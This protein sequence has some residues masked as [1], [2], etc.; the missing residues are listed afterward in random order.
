MAVPWRLQRYIFR[1]MGKTFVLT[2]LG[3]TGVLSL[4]GGV[5]NMIRL[6]EITPSQL[7]RLLALVVP[8]AA[9]L[10]LPVAALFSATSTYGRISADNEFVACRA[11]GINLHVLLLPTIV[12]SLFS[13]AVSFAFINFVIPDMVRNLNQFVSSDIGALLQQRLNRPRGMRFSDKYFLTADEAVAD[14]GNPNRFTLKRVVFVEVDAESWTRYGTAREVQMQ[15]ERG[16]RE[17]RASGR[18]VGLSFYD[19]KQDRF[20]DA[21]EQ[22]IPPNIL[23]Q[24][25]PEQIKY[26]T[27]GQLFHYRNHPNEWREVRDAMDHLRSQ[28]G[29]RMVCDSLWDDWSADRVVTLRDGNSRYTLHSTSEPVRGARDTGLQFMEATIEEDRSGRKRS[30][31]AERA[32]IELKGADSLDEAVIQISVYNARITSEG[33]TVER[34]KDTL[35]PVAVDPE[36]RRRANE[37]SADAL[38]LPT[39]AADGVDPLA[40]KRARVAHENGTAY[41][42]I[43]ATLHERAAFSISVLV[44]VILGATLA[45]VLRGSQPIVAFGI[46]FIPSVLV[47][48]TIVAG[49]QLAQ[50]GGTHSLGVF[51]LWSGIL[52]TAAVDYWALTRLLRR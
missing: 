29:R 24:A 1:E 32:E 52:F 31:I 16:E 11:S 41:R 12:L 19:R 27:L 10:T 18:M 2:S 46:G 4:G 39:S 17:I 40:E 20:T 25:L 37:L 38:M 5:L 9:A 33:R 42:R 49:K 48:L 50:G 51:V 7:T 6:G 36:L 22:I 44:L 28:M 13:A 26:L 35:G 45:I 30:C 14:P 15:F 3:L 21:E 34:S 47:I 43:V 23:P 8:V